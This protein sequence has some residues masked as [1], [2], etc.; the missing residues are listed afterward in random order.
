MTIHGASTVTD[1]VHSRPAPML[2][3]PRPPS[4]GNDVG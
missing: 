1:H 4:A 2:T 3:V